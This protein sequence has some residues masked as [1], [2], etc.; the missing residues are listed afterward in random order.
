M[1]EYLFKGR[2]VREDVVFTV[3]AENENAAV[4]KAKRGEWDDW[5]ENTGETTDCE[6]DLSTIELNE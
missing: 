6:L 5:D 1:P 3:K 4:M 2:I